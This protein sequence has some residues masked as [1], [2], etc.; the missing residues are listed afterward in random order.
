MEY[1]IQ[2]LGK[3]SGDADSLQL[4]FV[5]TV[6]LA[7]FVFGL[8]LMYLVGV[9]SDPLRKRLRH[10]AQPAGNAPSGQA[11]VFSSLR[12]LDPYILPKKDWER[13]RISAKL[14]HAGIRSENGLSVFYTIKMLLFILLPG[15]VIATASFMPSMTTNHVLLGVGAAGFTALVLPNMVLDRLALNRI[16]RIRNGFPDALDLLVVCSEAGLG[17]NAALQRVG[18]ELT[19]T[20]PELAQELVLVNAEIRVGVDRGE[21]LRNLARRTGVDDIRGLVALLTQS[22]RLGTGIAETLRI[23]AEELRDKRMQRAEELA[24]KLGTKMIFPLV[25]CMFPGFFVVI[26]GPAVLRIIATFGTVT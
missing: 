10:V 14:V 1:L 25:L 5:L 20:H 21:A 13:S 17:L 6:S 4:V 18:Q 7:F 3:I 16:T 12:Q 26:L 15:L 9:W 23:F 19:E 11:S 2:I 8:A 22:M 24:A